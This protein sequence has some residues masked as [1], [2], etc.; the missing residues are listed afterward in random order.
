MKPE[1]ILELSEE[2][3]KAKLINQIVSELFKL[4]SMELWKLLNR[5]LT[6]A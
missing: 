5:L 1:D 3:L 6:Q 4:D 2:E